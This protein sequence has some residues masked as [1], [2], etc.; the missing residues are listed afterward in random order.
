[1]KAAHSKSDETRSHILTIGRDLMSTRG[2]TGLGLGE[3]LKT[4]KVPKGS[5]YHYFESKEDFGCKLLEFYLEAYMERLNE[6]EA[7]HFNGR[8][9]LLHYWQRWIDTQSDSGCEQRCLIVKLSAEIADIS[10]PM[11]C[12]L[13]QGTQKVIDR[14]AHWIKDGQ[15]DGSLSADLDA[16]SLAPML[17]HMWLG[18]SL[19]AKLERS[20]KPFL[21]AKEASNA[22]LQPA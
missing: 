21:S 1:M 5:F 8:E 15:E 6:L 22:L 18:A 9:R 14:L 19:R 12:I 20:T 7:T 10:Q 11:G 13:A 16:E 3:L 17:Y 4:A 2:F